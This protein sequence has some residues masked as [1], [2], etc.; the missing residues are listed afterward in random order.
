[1]RGKGFLSEITVCI[2]VW[3]HSLRQTSA[4]MWGH[5]QPA[6][7]AAA[8]PWLV[9]LIFP[10]P[11]WLLYGCQGISLW[12][13]HLYTCLSPFSTAS[14]WSDVGALAAHCDGSCW[15]IASW[16]DFYN[17]FKSTLCA[18]R[19]SALKSPF[20]YLF[21]S[22]LYGEYLLWCWG[23]GSPLW[24]LLPTHGQLGWFLQ[25]LYTWYARH[26]QILVLSWPKR[27]LG[28]STV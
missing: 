2:P 27:C 12:S 6:V 5:W 16:A 11:I 4:L 21:E 28:D 15:P 25:F 8:Y 13:H 1:M 24:R 9:R 17:S 14:I 19:D 20:V 23:I 3:V 10:I 22:V 7:P 18:A 26:D